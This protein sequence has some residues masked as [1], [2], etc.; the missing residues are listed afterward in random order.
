MLLRDIIAD[1]RATQERDPA[2]RSFFEVLFLYQGVHALIAYRIAHWFWKRK[3]YFIARFI[4]Q[5]SRFMTLIEIH[6][7]AKLG[8]GILIDHGTGGAR[9]QLHH[10]PGGDPGRCGNQEGKAPSDHRQQC[11]HRRGRKDTGFL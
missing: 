7:G 3:H 10:I 4:S 2:A 6:P 9:R 11:D 8:K 1:V 5:L